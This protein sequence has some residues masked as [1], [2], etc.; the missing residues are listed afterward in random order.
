M[1]ISSTTGRS[2]VAAAP[3]AVP[4]S[5]ISLIGVSSTRSGPKVLISPL[6]VPMTP[7]ISSTSSLSRAPPP[8][9][10]SPMRITSGSL[11]MAMLSASLMAAPVERVRDMAAYSLT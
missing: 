2:P 11:C 10:S 3:T 8:A 5:P 1:N 6:V 9:T 4:S 7:P